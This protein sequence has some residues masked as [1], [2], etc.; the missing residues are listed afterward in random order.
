MAIEALAPG[1]QK[2]RAVHPLTHGQVD[3]PGGPS[4]R[5]MRTILPPLCRWGDGPVAPFDAHVLDVGPE[6]LEDAQTVEGEQR[7]QGV[8]PR[9]ADPGDDE[10]ASDLVAVEPDGVGLRVN[11]ATADIGSRRDGD[12]PGVS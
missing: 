1:G 7:D 4:A 8:I 10:D 12:Q 2:D 11:R 3:R 6:G 5:G 9:V